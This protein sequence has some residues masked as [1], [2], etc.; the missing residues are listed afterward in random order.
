MRRPRV[1]VLLSWLLAAL[2]TGLFLLFVLTLTGVVP[3]DSDASQGTPRETNAALPRPA[4][5]PPA[6]SEPTRPTTTRTA[7]APKQVTVVVTAT[8]GN[9]WVLARRGSETGRTLHEGVLARGSSTTVRARRIW[10]SLGA[11]GNVDV[12]VDGKPRTI[13]TGTIAMIFEATPSA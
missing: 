5:P 3:R 7:P 13:T 1:A 8:R 10:L 12:T 4:P 9:C 2:A 6:T 11:S